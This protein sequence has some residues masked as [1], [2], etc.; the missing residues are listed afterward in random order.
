MITTNLSVDSVTIYEKKN[1][2]SLMKEEENSDIDTHIKVEET[3]YYVKGL[4]FA[5]LNIKNINSLV[6]EQVTNSV[7]SPLKLKLIRR[8]SENFWR[9]MD[10]KIVK[11]L[12]WE[13]TQKRICVCHYTWLWLYLLLFISWQ[14]GKWCVPSIFQVQIQNSEVSRR[15]ACVCYCANDE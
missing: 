15:R 9:K 14:R 5:M 3:K 11:Q 4:N 13:L 12:L 6:Y 10:L 7:Q 1:P 2:V 8:K